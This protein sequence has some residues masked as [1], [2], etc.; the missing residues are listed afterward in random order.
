MSALP[1]IAKKNPD[2]NSNVIMNEFNEHFVY[3]YN[4]ILL[5]ADE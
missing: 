3:S 5:N 1:I 2:S 4:G